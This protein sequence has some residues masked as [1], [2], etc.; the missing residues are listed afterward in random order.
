MRKI[1]AVIALC[2]AP[3][4]SAAPTGIGKF[5]DEDLTNLERE[6]VPLVEEMPAGQYQFAPS[7]G[8]FIGVRTF[9]VQ[10]RHV[11]A[12]TFLVSSA[13]LAEKNPSDPGARENGPDSLK[14]KEEIVKYLK[15]AFAYAHKAMASLTDS[16]LAD[17]VKSPFG[18]GEMPRIKMATLI[19]AH[20]FDHYGQLVVYLRMKGIVPPASR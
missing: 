16:N 12:V 15:D 20:G 4:F 8:E 5:L 18:S 10:V 19:T 3:A 1:I 6:I 11:A 2:C 14:N 7:D 17:M 9:G 13:I